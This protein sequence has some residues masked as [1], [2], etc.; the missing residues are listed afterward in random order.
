MQ[1][2]SPF[3]A[4][5]SMALEN[6]RRQTYPEAD[7]NEAEQDQ[8]GDKFHSSHA[9]CFRGLICGNTIRRPEEQE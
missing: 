8:D 5:A 4:K 3:P 6:I 2:S 9:K 7:R 1:P